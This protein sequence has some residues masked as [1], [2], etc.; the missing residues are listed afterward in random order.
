MKIVNKKITL[1]LFTYGITLVFCYLMAVSPTIKYYNQYNKQLETLANFKKLNTTEKKLYQKDQQLNNFLNTYNR[2]DN[3]T[4]QNNLLQK[5][6]RFCTTDKLEIIAFNAPH[7]FLS[8]GII[9][10]SYSFTLKGNYKDILE[11]LN[12]IEN[13]PGIGVI[14]SIHFIKKKNYKTGKNYLTASVIL[15]KKENNRTF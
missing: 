3:T 12:S 4:F 6:N 8:H 14:K 2:D 7:L 15:E 13:S 9:T 10:S 5:L 1:L 11:T